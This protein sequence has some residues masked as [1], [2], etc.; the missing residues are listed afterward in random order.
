[1]KDEEDFMSMLDDYIDED[2]INQMIDQENRE[3][4]AEEQQN[5]KKSNHSTES[6]FPETIAIS[7]KDYV[8]HYL[9]IASIPRLEI[10]EHTKYKKGKKVKTKT[11]TRINYDTLWHHGLK[12]IGS[13]LV[14]G[15]DNEYANKNPDKVYS[16]ELLLVIDSKG[17]RGTY[18]NPEFIKQLIESEDI[19]QELKKLRR[20]GIHQLDELEEYI[21][22]CVNLQV[23]YE[24]TLKQNKK[25]LEMLKETHK[26]RKFKELK[27]E[28]KKND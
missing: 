15:V 8:E 19:E 6:R 22:E 26:M 23:K 18:V 11:T 20:T 16:G 21:R 2:E 28:L 17:N 24:T 1:M 4:K 25:T 10:V 13:P 9:G 3:E 27:K 7:I 5:R 14:F 12:E